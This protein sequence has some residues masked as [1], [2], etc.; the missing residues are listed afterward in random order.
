ME[1]ES[2]LEIMGSWRCRE[3][4]GLQRFMDDQEP[5]TI[6]WSSKISKHSLLCMTLKDHK[7]GHAVSVQ[8]E[9]HNQWGK[10]LLFCD[11]YKFL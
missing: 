5:N 7:N 10:M 11:L 3:D 1:G 6:G 4:C 8:N 9:L 2:N